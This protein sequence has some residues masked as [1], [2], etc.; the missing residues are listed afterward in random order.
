MVWK[1]SSHCKWKT[2]LSTHT[3]AS[4]PALY[5]TWK[6]KLLGFG[7]PQ[8]EVTTDGRISQIIP[9]MLAWWWKSLGHL[10]NSHV[11][12]NFGPMGQICHQFVSGKWSSSR[13]SSAEHPCF[14]W[15]SPTLSSYPPLPFHDMSGHWVPNKPT[16]PGNKPTSRDDS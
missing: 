13:R 12:I 8:K 1:S 9:S 5:T 15:S 10:H 16:R 11:G 2:I 7:S 6:V 14:T 3:L 4:P